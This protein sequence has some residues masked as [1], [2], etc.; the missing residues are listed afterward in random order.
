MATTAD[1]SLVVSGT[2]TTN[3]TQTPNGSLNAAITGQAVTNFSTVTNLSINSGV[4]QNIFPAGL[5]AATKIQYFGFIHYD[6]ADISGGTAQC[7]MNQDAVGATDAGFVF[8]GI[9]DTSLT[10]ANTTATSSVRVQMAWIVL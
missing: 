10:L 9:A 1:I 5:P 3:N 4:T 7:A 6:S 8:A 2:D